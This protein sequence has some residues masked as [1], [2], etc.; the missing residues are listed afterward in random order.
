[1]YGLSSRRMRFDLIVNL[2]TL[3]AWKNKKIIVLGGGKQWRP[4]VHVDDVIN[5]FKLVVDCANKKKVYKEIFNVGSN[6]QNYQ[7]SQVAN[8]VKKI[9][10]DTTVY[11]APDDP[12]KR[13]Y[14]VN[15]DK[16]KNILNFYPTKS[17]EDGV[18]EIVD[19][20][21]NGQV[22][23]SLET[24]TVKYYKHLIDSDKLLSKVKLNGSL[25]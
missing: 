6:A 14:N 25:F 16:I 9:L 2:M 4:L 15:F 24:V 21:E 13:N 11:D 20:L 1:M 5:A 17:V 23:D 3:H 18:K 8:I 7:V 10:P 12:D 22:N 19:A